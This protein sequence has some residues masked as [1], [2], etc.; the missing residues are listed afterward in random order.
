MTILRNGSQTATLGSAENFTGR[1]RVENTFAAAEPARLRGA[2]VSFEPGARSHWHTHPLG[3][4][5]IVTA[6]L[7]WHQCEGGPIEE[8]R[9]GD[10]VQCAC[11][12]RHWHGASPTIG[13]SHL[14]LQEALDGKVV[15]WMEPVT[16][17]QYL[18]GPTT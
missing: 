15:E 6:G 2:L 3:Q 17:E 13:M 12:H 18:S 8:I 9:P 4:T 5:L 11:N 16:D 1:V 14:A 7:G 10:V